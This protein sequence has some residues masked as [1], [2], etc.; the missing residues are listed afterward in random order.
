LPEP[1]TLLIGCAIAVAVLCIV[2]VR[3]HVRLRNH[4]ADAEVAID[5]HRARRDALRAELRRVGARTVV[6][7]SDAAPPGEPDE[8][9]HEQFAEAEDRLAAI[10]RLRDAQVREWNRM[11]A[12]P[13]WRQLRAV[14]GWRRIPPT[15]AGD[16]AQD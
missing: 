1:L 12:T 6:P 9:L 15:D 14:T 11:G 8:L 16:D 3:R 5:A 4:I 7:A 2:Q 13:P 10:R